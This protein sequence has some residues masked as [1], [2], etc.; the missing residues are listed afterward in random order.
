MRLYLHAVAV[1]LACGAVAVAAAFLARGSQST[2]SRTSIRAR[3]NLVLIAAVA[4]IVAIT[5]VPTHGEHRFRLTPLE[6]IGDAL[7]PPLDHSLLFELAGNL[8]LFVPLGAAL[9]FR[10]LALGKAVIGAALS[11]AAVEITQ[12]M[13]TGRTTSTDDAFL[14]TLG[15]ILGYSLAA[16]FRT[17][18]GTG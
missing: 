3:Q 17:R 7:T 8:I 16:T 6:E 15:A 9:C 5:L 10:G 18:K 4:A 13:I 12:I 11:S 14:N 1:L 2:A